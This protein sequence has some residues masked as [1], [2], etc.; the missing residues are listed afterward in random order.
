M[1]QIPSNSEHIVS[2]LEKPKRMLQSQNRCCKAK[3]DAAGDHK[4]AALIFHM[5]LRS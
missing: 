2:S 4:V 5:H 1:G 3:T